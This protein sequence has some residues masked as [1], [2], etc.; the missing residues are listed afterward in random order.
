MGRG[1]S[2]NNFVGLKVDLNGFSI[3]FLLR[4]STGYNLLQADVFIDTYRYAHL[5]VIYV[6]LSLK[7]VWAL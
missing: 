6:S 3:A 4:T 5:S 7:N 2:T 1:I